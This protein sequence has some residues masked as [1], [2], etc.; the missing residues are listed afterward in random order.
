MCSSSRKGKIDV[1]SWES[2]SETLGTKRMVSVVAGM[3]NEEEARKLQHVERE[4]FASAVYSTERE[5]TRVA[6]R[7]LEVEDYSNSYSK[8]AWSPF[9]Q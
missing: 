8:S 1:G 9:D 6:S 7:S 5:V 2:K 4:T 3:T